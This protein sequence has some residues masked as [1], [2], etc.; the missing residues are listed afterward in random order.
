MKRKLLAMLTATV[1][2][3][4][5]AVGCGNENTDVTS[6]GPVL[7]VTGG[8][9][10]GYVAENGVK[11]FKGIPYAA[12]SEGE[13]R[14]KE[15]QPVEPWDSVLDCTEYGSI[16]MQNEDTT[17]G[18]MAPWTTEFKDLGKTFE[19]GQISEDS[20]TVNVWTNAE[21]GDN[22]PV[23][24][25][26]YGGGNNHGSGT[27]ENYA[28]EEIANKDV[29]YVTFNYR[30]AIFGFLAY[31][32]STGEELTG[33]YAIMDQLAV[34]NWLQ[35]N[36][37]QFGGDPSNVT[38]A[39]QSAGAM[40]VQ[41]L[42]A[43]PESAGLFSKAVVMSGN[44]MM[45]D[46]PTKESVEEEA[47]AAF[48]DYTIEELRAMSSEDVL[49][50]VTGMGVYNP[51][52]AC[53]DGTI[54]T[55]SP[56]NA[57]KSGEYNNVDMIIGSVEKDALLFSTVAYPDPDGFAFTPITEVSP[58]DYEKAIN[59]AFGNK[60]SSYLQMYSVDTSVE[61]VIE[62]ANLVN[63]D[64][65]ISKDYY[66]TKLKDTGDPEKKTY[67]YY[68]DHI[69]PDTPER[70]TEHGAFH[71]SDVPYWLNHF[72]ESYPR[73]W[74]DVDYNLG[75]TMSSYLVNFAYNGDPN[76]E[77]LPEWPESS[78]T[79]GI[80][81][82]NFGDTVELKSFDETKASLWSEYWDNMLLK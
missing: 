64:A 41:T 28:G 14:W 60:A 30:V 13:N 34:L 50:L 61:N 65:M 72:T 53:I 78:T 27:I 48:G 33:N 8:D 5:T 62:T 19:N 29:V 45:M 32:D 10:M 40:N 57:F 74:T 75:D 56:Y 71:T 42:L 68:F 23:I 3:T 47:T 15:P 73:T 1:M 39:G 12:S 44:S 26:I 67:V 9:I 25:Y 43:S 82:L 51:S 52:T 59:D 11:V 4:L 7:S 16:P 22:K 2:I 58:T 81:Y 17:Y 55:Q 35:D 54:V 76:G 36:I 24:V 66:T 49:A 20:H 77:G 63:I 46:V 18:G 37:E 38:I 79:T 70:M 80:T 31:K 21:T 69:I 6:D